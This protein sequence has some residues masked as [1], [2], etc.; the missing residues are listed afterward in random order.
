VQWLLGCAVAPHSSNTL[1]AP[2]TPVA[3]HTIVASYLDAISRR[4]LLTLTLYVTP[5]VEWYSVS[6]GERT[7]ESA[8]REQ[9]TALFK[10]H[11]GRYR[12]T[13]WSIE[14][15]VETGQHVAIV[16]RSEWGNDTTESKVVLGEFELEADRIRRITYFL[17]DH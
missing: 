12:I 14:R 16:E 6:K 5:D 2:H 10:L 7:L 1:V 4:D 8:G 3:S 15:F 9:L 13:R 17:N 11:Y